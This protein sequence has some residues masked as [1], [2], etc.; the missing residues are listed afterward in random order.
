MHNT[1]CW[2]LALPEINPKSE[3]QTRKMTQ[4]LAGLN[5]GF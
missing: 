5:F 1:L 4:Y 2:S 3:I